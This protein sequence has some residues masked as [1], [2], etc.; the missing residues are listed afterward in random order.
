MIARKFSFVFLIFYRSLL[1]SVFLMGRR[2]GVHSAS[3]ARMS[4]TTF[5][6]SSHRSFASGIRSMM[7]YYIQVAF[8]CHYLEMK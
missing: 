4:H 3:K 2:E 8:N 5:A 6:A 1:L 7:G